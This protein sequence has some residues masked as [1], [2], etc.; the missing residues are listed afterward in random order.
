MPEALFEF[1]NSYARLPAAFYERLDPRP[2]PKPKLLAWNQELARELGMREGAAEDAEL[3]SLF[4]GARV[5]EGAEPLAQIYAGHQFGHFSPQLGDGRALLLGEVVDVH[6]ARKDIQL[7]GS[8]PTPFS[9]GGDGFAALGPVLREYLVSEAMHALGVPTTRSLAA[10]A[11]G[12]PV[13][14]ERLLP[15]AVL[16]RIAASHLRVGTFEL[17][18]SRGQTEEVTQLLD[19]AIARHDP[20]LAKRDDRALA[21]IESVGA[22]QAALVARWMSIGF[23]HGVM[24]TDNSS[25]S[26]ETIDYGPCAFL[27]YYDPYACFSSIDRHGRYAFSRQSQ[28]AQWNL[29]RLASSLLRIIDD[30]ETRSIETA[31][32]VVKNFGEAFKHAFDDAMRQ[33][34]GLQARE[35]ADSALIQELLDA[36]HAGKADFTRCFRELTVAAEDPAAGAHDALRAQF[37]GPTCSTAETAAAD[38]DAWFAKWSARCARE[39]RSA[40]ERAAA[41]RA[42]NPVYIPRNHLV[43]E[44]L[45]AAEAGD[46]G[47]FERMHTVLARPFEE[48]DGAERYAR[49]GELDQGDYRT[50]CGT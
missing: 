24:N 30:D 50:F 27:D 3:A 14:R 13:M 12:D 19:Y 47:P 28:I 22:R 23:V 17:F 32:E 33:K 38:F 7:K 46:L 8:G 42:T 20:E 2:A 26:G 16:T 41:M 15:G 18:A 49:A 31:T 11:T 36:M 21:F 37:A 34:L 35:D 4:G 40:A 1:D 6:G 25:I 29:A 45:A 44:A 48:Q 5:P 43:E 39:A 9:R 10:V